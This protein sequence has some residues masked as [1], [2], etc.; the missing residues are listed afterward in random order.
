MLTRKGILNIG[1]DALIIILITFALG[2]LGLRIYNYIDPLPIFYTES[3]NRWR[4]K[5]FASY[6]SFHLNSQGFNDVELARRKSQVQL[7]SSASETASPLASY[8]TNT[9]I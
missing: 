3:Y 8:H 7:A 5:P 1:R 2:E 9:I 4:G 6:L